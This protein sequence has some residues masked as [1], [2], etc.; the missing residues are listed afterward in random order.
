MKK[1]KFSTFGILAILVATFSMR[2]QGAASSSPSP[3]PTATPQ[4]TGA[5]TNPVKNE[6]PQELLP[7]VANKRAMITNLKT[8]QSKQTSLITDIDDKIK[9]KLQD[10]QK[11]K[12]TDDAVASEIRMSRLQESMEALEKRRR[13]S[14]ERSQFIDRLVFAVD[15]KWG[16]GTFKIFLE[17][18]LLDIAAAEMNQTDSKAPSSLWKFATY[19]SVAVRELAEPREDLVAFVDNY[20]D[21]SSVLDPKPPTAFSQARSYTNGFTSQAAKRTNREDL[22]DGIEKK[23]K[24][25]GADVINDPAVIQG[26]TSEPI[27]PEEKPSLPTTGNLENRN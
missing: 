27:E 26:S 4:Q 24:V 19:L 7:T 5:L 23:V 20:M 15:T 18:A 21:F 17:R 13:E 1:A 8:I 2:A 22:G 11:V 16:Q 14:I 12:V 9:G 3:T 6:N 10:T 25:L